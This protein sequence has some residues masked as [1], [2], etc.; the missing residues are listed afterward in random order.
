[1]ELVIPSGQ[2]NVYE[3]LKAAVV[4]LPVGT[5][6]LTAFFQALDFSDEDLRTASMLE[7]RVLAGSGLHPISD[8]PLEFETCERCLSPKPVI[9]PVDEVV[10]VA[11]SEPSELVLGYD[12]YRL[13]RRELVERVR[14]AGL[15]CG[16]ATT[17]CRILFAGGSTTEYLWLRAVHDL[18]LPRG[19]VEFEKC[20]QCG[21]LNLTRNENFLTIFDANA[22][23]AADFATSS[24]FDPAFLAVSRRVYQFLREQPD[25]PGSLIFEPLECE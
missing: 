8:L 6:S 5:V 7:L 22:C 16:M 4:R 9:R 15:D 21:Q 2:V 17:P 23:R 13:A 11:E 20:P 19:K 1:M 18:G 25:L 3:D 14:T 12:V 10:F 24:F